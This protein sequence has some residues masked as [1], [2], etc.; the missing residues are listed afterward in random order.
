[1]DAFIDNYTAKNKT[2]SQSTKN[3]FKTSI[4][5]LEKFLNLKYDEWDKDTFKHSGT[6]L[7]GLID[8]YSVNTIIQT[9]LLIIR[10]LEYKDN[11]AQLLTKYKNLLNDLIQERTKEEHSQK[12]DNNEKENWI[13]YDELKK[14]VED[15]IPYYL[16]NK[17]AFTDFRNFL[18]LA[19]FTLQPPTRIGNYLDMKYKTINKKDIKSLNKKYNYISK[20]GDDKYKMVFNNYKTSK[21]IGKIEHT[22]T[23]DNLNKLIDRWFSD[24]NKKKEWFITNAN[25]KPISQTNF[26]NGQKSISKK[27]IG[28]ELTT[29]LFRHIFLTDFLKGNPSLEEKKKIAQLVGQKYHVSRMELYYRK[30]EK[31]EDEDEKDE[32]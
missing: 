25:G 9:V 6:I 23:N 29:N 20:V 16:D 4:K 3:T 5:R 15:K 11:N 32:E 31:D 30:D 10:W 17:R 1:M 28:K 13:S 7:D 21:Y 24:Y 2:K 12:K 19:L 27:V 18:I 8:D 26:T 22:I 14:K